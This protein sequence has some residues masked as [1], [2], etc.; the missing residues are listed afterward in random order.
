MILG[1]GTFLAAVPAALAGGAALGRDLLVLEDGPRGRIVVLD[2]ASYVTPGMLRPNDVVIFA[3]YAGAHV[4]E[5]PL[6]QGFKAVIADDAGI[7]KDGAGVSALPATEKFGIA[8]AAVD[9]RS[10]EMSNGR[11]LALGKISRA[12]APALALGVRAGQPAYEAARLMLAAPAGK[13]V[14]LGAS[15]PPEVLLVDRTAT[16][17]VY[18]DD[19]SEHFFRQKG[20]VPDDVI[21]I[22]S[23]CSR[24]FAESVVRMSPRGAMANDCGMGLNDTAVGGLPILAQ[25]GIAAASVAT[26]SALVGSGLSTWRDGIVSVVNSVARER[27][28]IVGMP[29]RDAARAMLG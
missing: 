25:Q 22:G 8:A 2:S 1:R 14:Q 26:L 21:C 18:A 7:G 16:G 3:S 13:A 12:N 15:P 4:V 27:G 17:V 9:T 24:V 10:A 11:S 29:A 28:V 6:R 23:N 19:S 5:A 20:R